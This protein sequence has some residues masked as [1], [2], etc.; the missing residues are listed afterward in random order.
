MLHKFLLKIAHTNFTM[1]KLW[2]G[3]VDSSQPRIFSTT[4]NTLQFHNLNPLTCWSSPISFYLWYKSLLK[5]VH[6]NFTMAKLWCDFLVFNQLRILSTTLNTLQLHN[7]NP[8]TC[9]LS[10]I[11]FWLL[12]KL[13]LNIVHTNFTM[14]QFPTAVTSSVHLQCWPMNIPSTEQAMLYPLALLLG[15]HYKFSLYTYVSNSAI[16]N[17]ASL[18]PIFRTFFLLSFAQTF[19][20][21]YIRYTKHI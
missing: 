1:V 19:Y 18:G 6:T 17:L 16:L 2:S 15:I 9:C 20:Y 14:G 4:L 10:L 7:L 21:H 11:S 8:V 3:L 13:W 5:I 12:Q